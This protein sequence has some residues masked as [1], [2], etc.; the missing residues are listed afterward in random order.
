LGVTAVGEDIADAVAEAYTA[1]GKIAW[2]GMHFRRDIGYRAL[3]RSSLAARGCGAK[4]REAGRFEAE[5]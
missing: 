2:E 3:Q 4:G 5:P 1:V